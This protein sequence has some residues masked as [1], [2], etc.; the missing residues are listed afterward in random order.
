MATATKSKPGFLAGLKAA[1]TAPAQ[2]DWAAKEAAAERIFDDAVQAH[3]HAAYNSQVELPGAHEALMHAGQV[4]QEAR[5]NLETVRAAR[6][7]GERLEGERLASVRA[8][9]DAKQDKTSRAAFSRQADWAARGQEVIATYV[10]WFAEGATIFRDCQDQF[11]LNER[12]RQDMQHYSLVEPI[13]RE[14]AKQAVA[15]TGPNKPMP[16]GAN[17]LAV[18]TSDPSDWPTIGEHFAVLAKGV[19]A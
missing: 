11:G 1:I 7:E 17:V 6:V 19:I 9:E 4:L 15:L 5:G 13:G 2:P 8:A 14:I 12:V 3:R 16:P 18:T 10:Q